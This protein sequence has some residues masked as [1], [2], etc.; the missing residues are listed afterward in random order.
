MTLVLVTH[1]QNVADRAER[2]IRMRD[3]R[4]LEA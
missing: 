3:G 4:V 2:I 1:D